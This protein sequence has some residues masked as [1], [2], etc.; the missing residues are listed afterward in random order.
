MG[1]PDEIA[2]SNTPEVAPSVDEKIAVVTQN[3]A[4]DFSKGELR[5]D[6]EAGELAAQALASGPAEAEISKK[7]LRKIDLY[8]L[9][10]LCITYGKSPFKPLTT[11]FSRPDVSARSPI[12]R[13]DHFGIL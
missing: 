10:F 6:D 12:P 4:G 2:A 11:L 3:D 5:I 13:Q 1:S 7:V 9:P 8:I